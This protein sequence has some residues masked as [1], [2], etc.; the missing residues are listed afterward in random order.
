MALVS[1]AKYLWRRSIRVGNSQ[2]APDTMGQDSFTYPTEPLTLAVIGCGQRGK[3][4]RA[5]AQSTMYTY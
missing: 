2:S 5:A 3:V 1:N 4:R